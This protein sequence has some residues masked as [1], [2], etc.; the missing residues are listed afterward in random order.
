[1]G[2]T[3]TL[4]RQ[5][6]H[7]FQRMGIHQR[8]LEVI[9]IFDPRHRQFRDHTEFIAHF[10]DVEVRFRTDDPYS[11]TWFYPRYADGGIHEKK[12]TELLIANL[13]GKK[14]FLD[15]G[16]NLGWYT[17]IAACHLKNGVVYGFEMD[18][19]NYG[20][21]QKN[22]QANRATNTVAFH[23]AVSHEDGEVSYKRSGSKPSSFFQM[24]HA[25]GSGSHMITVKAIRMDSFFD[26]TRVPPDV[27]KI[28]VEGAE[29]SVLQGMSRIL[30]EHRPVLFLEIHPLYLRSFGSSTQELLTFLDQHGYEVRQIEEMRDDDHELEMKV[31]TPNTTVISNDMLLCTPRK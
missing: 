2:L 3:R 24:D 18:D 5:V 28:D 27:V 16:T 31:L 12:V 10:G 29:F 7:A 4:R 30:R 22:L 23:A 19:L 14:S 6:K 20:L 1:M 9:R 8:T 17:C 15:I 11:N 13:Q 25:N 26:Q 21:L